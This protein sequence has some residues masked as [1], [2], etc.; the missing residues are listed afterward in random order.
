MKKFLSVVLA[1]AMLLS[2]ASFALA[3]YSGDVKIWVAENVVDFTKNR[4][5]FSKLPILNMP[6]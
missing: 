6:T 2:F 5:K 1:L 3:D 4:W